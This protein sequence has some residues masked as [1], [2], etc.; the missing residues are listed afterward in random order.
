MRFPYHDASDGQ[1]EGLVVEICGELLGDGIQPFSS[2]PDGGRDARFEG[3]AQTFPSKTAPWSGKTIVQAKHTEHPYAKFSD[4]DYSGDGKT[5][6]L[7][8]EMRRIGQLVKSGELDHYMLFSNRRLAGEADSAIRKRIKAETG[9]KNVELFGVERI[10]KQLKT[11]PHIAARTGIGGLMVPLLISPDDLAHV[12]TEFYSQ[13]AMIS[14]ATKPVD[15]LER[16]TFRT[17]NR[18]NGLSDA[19]AKEIRS[20]YLAQFETVK[21][22]LALPG[23]EA[24]RERYDEAAAELHEK[25]LAHRKDYQDFDK[26]LVRLQD[27]LFRRDSDLAAR[28]RITKLVLYY[29]YWNCDIGASPDDD[30]AA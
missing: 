29:M 2:G 28:K 8:V 25:L 27:L 3:V 16:T 13:R 6:V 10:D 22:F 9:V 24:I 5:A 20:R 15:E 21:H 19:F 30:A 4:S 1:F 14:V 7:T 23:N 26:V 18:V 11:Y 17:K 12:I